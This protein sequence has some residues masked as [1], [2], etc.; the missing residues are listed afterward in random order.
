M[1]DC[2][3]EVVNIFEKLRAIG[4]LVGNEFIRNP[5]LNLP[6]RVVIA[7]G[8]KDFETLGPF[9]KLEE[10]YFKLHEDYWNK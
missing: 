6:S 7:S 2:S 3:K 8:Q 1:Q 4:E 10:E 9:L 5:T